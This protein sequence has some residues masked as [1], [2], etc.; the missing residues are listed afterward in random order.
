MRLV[1]E[2]V[3]STVCNVREAIR[4]TKFYKTHGI[5]N[6]ENMRA[7]EEFRGFKF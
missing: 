3:T 4:G 6:I 1:G 7:G 5:F 2:A